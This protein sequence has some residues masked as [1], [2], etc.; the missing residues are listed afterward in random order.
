MQRYQLW[1]NKI[2]SGI[3]PLKFRFDDKTF[4]FVANNT[5]T[6]TALLPA[7]VRICSNTF[8]KLTGFANLQAFTCDHDHCVGKV[9]GYIKF[10]TV[11]I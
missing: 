7:K 3:G 10:Y 8:I 1:V 4:Y 2:I 9:K 5:V 6:M 11:M